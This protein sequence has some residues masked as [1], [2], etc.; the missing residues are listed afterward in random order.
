[1][2]KT[3][4][5]LDMVRRRA[6]KGLLVLLWLHL[7]LLLAI[8]LA[9]GHDWTG[10]EALALALAG[11]ASL[12]CWRAPDSLNTRLTVAVAMIGMVSLIVYQL[13]GQAWQID[14]HLYFF[15][16]LAILA[17]YCDWRVLL[18]AAAAAALY[19]LALE[20]L[21][22]AAVFPNG[23]D[24]GRVV[25]HA[26]I[27]VME[28][29]ALMWLTGTLVNLFAVSH[30]AVQAATS[31]QAE[32]ALGHAREAGAGGRA[33][34]VLQQS[35]RDLTRV[36]EADVGTL[37]RDV[38][39]AVATVRQ[40]V[41]TVSATVLTSVERTGSIAS[42]SRDTAVN[43][44]TVA[45]AAEELSAS[46]GEISGQ[47]ARAAQIARVAADKTDQT[48]ETI[49]S[50]SEVVGKIETVV[51]LIS[52][53]ASQTNLLA[54]N[55]T[56]EAARAGDAGKGFAIVASEVK[57]LATQTTR[58]TGEIR[59]QIAAIQEETGRAV[60]AIGGITD[61]IGDLGAITVAVA[62]AIEEQGAATAEIARSAQQ[63][64]L[65]TESIS[66]NLSALEQAASQTG[67]AAAA[68]QDA[69]GRLS[70]DWEKMTG[71]VRGFVVSLSAA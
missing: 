70:A 29:S 36:F 55:A 57:S 11:T 44:Q 33:E 34:A 45:S 60:L 16:A 48:S 46:V 14:S 58:A 4:S 15:A 12:C 49:R 42:A 63:A 17:T 53:I 38:A 64:A 40:N 20:V 7:P 71:S 24:F 10:S 27:L 39:E 62:T 56:I 2:T 51:G 59:T 65:G 21:L 52:G 41:A 30:A 54:L 22:P 37:M 23:A 32:S 35:R 13:H 6:G 68:S 25:L 67:S 9:V 3:T 28:T 66:S 47:I 19:H 8:A 43:V 61:V 69:S 18:M 31:A 5:D 50:L 26:V 1:M